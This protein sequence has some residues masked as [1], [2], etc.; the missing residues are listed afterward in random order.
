MYLF[1]GAGPRE[2]RSYS[3]GY[4][5][6]GSKRRESAGVRRLRDE[7]S[8]RIQYPQLPARELRHGR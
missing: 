5:V 4:G 3:D 8:V 7:L 1:P 6:Y 2:R